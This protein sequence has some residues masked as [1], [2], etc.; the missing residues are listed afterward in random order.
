MKTAEIQKQKLAE[1]C[2]P[3]CGVKVN[4]TL[5]SEYLVISLAD[6]FHTE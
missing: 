3:D 4:A 5:Q 2:M 6:S 1:W